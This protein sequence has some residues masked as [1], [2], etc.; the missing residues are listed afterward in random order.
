[1]PELLSNSIAELVR[2]NPNAND[3]EILEVSKR[4]VEKVIEHYKAGGDANLSC[5]REGFAEN[6]VSPTVKKYESELSQRPDII[7]D[8]ENDLET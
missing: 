3:I 5:S 8:G 1:M 7:G 2:D 4:L 6:V